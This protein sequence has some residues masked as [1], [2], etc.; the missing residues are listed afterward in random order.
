MCLYLDKRGAVYYFHRAIPDELSAFAA[1]AALSEMAP[2]R[3]PE[4][5]W[6]RPYPSHEAI[7]DSGL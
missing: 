6:Q 4:A 3:V 5:F 1:R 2:Q 7:P